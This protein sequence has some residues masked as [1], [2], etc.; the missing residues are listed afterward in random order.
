MAIE[1]ERKFLVRRGLWQHGTVPGI[2]YR[3]GYLSTELGRVVR[4]RLAGA[5]GFLTIKGA[6][7][8]IAR[9]E[10]EYPV[11]RADAEFM[12]DQLCIRPLIEKQ[13]YR[14]RFGGHIWEVDEFEGENAGLIVAEIELPRPDADFAAPPWVGREVSGDPRYSNARLVTHPYR[15]WVPRE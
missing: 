4:V 3:Q 8:G 9:A 12:L 10:F 1:I 5:D 15:D 6:S 13:R 2:H 7:S 14:V 11:P